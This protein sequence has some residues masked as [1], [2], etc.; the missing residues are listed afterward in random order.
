MDAIT[1]PFAFRLAAPVLA[2][3]LGVSVP[4]FA[5][6][7]SSR[8]YTPHNLVSD[9]VGQ[10][11]TT[12]SGL[13][14]AWGLAF[15]PYGPAWVTGNGSGT[16]T[17]YTGTGVKQSL[18]VTIP[19]PSGS[20]T[21]APTGVVF[22]GSNG[23]TGSDV[24]FPVTSNGVKG[25]SVFV[26]ATEDGTL[27]GWS[28]SVD[29]KNA[30]I[31]VDNSAN[32]AI[33]KGLALGGDGTRRLL[34]ATDFHNNR[35]DVFDSQFAPV[36]DLP[37]GAFT[38]PGLPAGYAPFGI[39]FIAGALYVTY[40]KQDGNAKDDVPGQGQGFVDVYSPKGDL[41]R[42]LVSRG[43]LNAPWAV[44]LAPPNFGRFSNQILVGNFGNG[45]VNAY[46]PKNGS[47][48]GF[49]KQGSG[50]ALAVD[51]LWALEFGNGVDNQPTN[52]LFFTAGPGG[53]AH[54]LYG[55]IDPTTP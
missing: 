31:A 51:G 15:N 20:G 22:N 41:L 49:L 39:H 14:N 45:R 34:Y 16:S 9:Q 24:Q 2:L 37:T 23:F 43:K 10:A 6:P 38:D 13:V 42:R 40:A 33:Y 3:S 36:T 48:T 35:I 50:S 26:F 28:P 12:D 27:A 21:A 17:I 29:A 55:Y 54:G 25:S 19:T 30:I 18:T 5:A 1:R 47:F 8:V 44:A 53:E 11:D 32:K 4:L 46:D 52:R 7:G